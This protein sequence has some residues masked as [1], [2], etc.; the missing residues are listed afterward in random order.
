[1]AALTRF[2]ARAATRE[3]TWFKWTLIGV[4]LTFFAVFLLLPLIT[5][6]HEALKKITDCP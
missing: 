4:S 2:E 1:M 6:F 5:V 3:P